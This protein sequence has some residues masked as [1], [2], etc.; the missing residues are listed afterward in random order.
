[1]WACS[2]NVGVNVEVRRVQDALSD[3]RYLQFIQGE[4]TSAV[5]QPRHHRAVGNQTGTLAVLRIVVCRPIPP[6]CLQCPSHPPW[7]LFRLH[8]VVGEHRCCFSPLHTSLLCWSCMWFGYLWAFQF[9]RISQVKMVVGTYDWGVCRTVITVSWR[10]TSRC[11]GCSLGN[12]YRKVA[13]RYP[14]PVALLRPSPYPPLSLLSSSFC[15]V[16]LVGN[17]IFEKKY[18]NFLACFHI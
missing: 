8:P 16:C 7:H 10:R 4:P 2:N 18:F 15:L 11:L 3:K 6:L 14:E 13:T 17:L 9:S 12:I 1:M 5:S